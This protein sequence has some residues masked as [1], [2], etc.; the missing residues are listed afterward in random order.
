MKILVASDIHGNARCFKKVIDFFC[1]EQLDEIILLGDIFNDYYASSIDDKDISRMLYSIANKLHVIMGNNDS[2]YSEELLPTNYLTKHSS[3][4]N[5][6]RIVFYHGDKEVYEL[7]DIYV[8]GHTH[9]SSLSKDASTIYVNPGSV[10]RPRDNSIGSFIVIDDDYISL[11]DL[12][13]KVL[14]ILKI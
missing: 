6:K 2:K 11:Y 14:D 12:E 4:I 7:Y 13:Y 10:G 1:F 9:R 5:D 8:Q 3:I